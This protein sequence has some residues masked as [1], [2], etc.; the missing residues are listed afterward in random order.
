MAACRAEQPP[1]VPGVDPVIFVTVGTQLPFDRL[2]RAVDEW[3]GRVGRTDIFAQTGPTAYEPRSI[4]WAR[5]LEPAAFTARVHE[6]A[7][8]IA[9]AGMGTIV[10]AL[11]ARI[12]IVV[13]PRQAALGE[14]RNDHQVATVREL[15]ARRLIHV[16]A[17]EQALACML[18][19]VDELAPLHELAESASGELVAYVRGFIHRQ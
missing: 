14:H 17:N 5:D 4:L 11:C 12:P 1:S 15:G 16:A 9:H 19:R 6:A 3:A 2:I 18:D 8:I 13:M 7:L 10:N